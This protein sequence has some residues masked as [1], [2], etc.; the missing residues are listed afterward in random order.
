MTFPG[1][2]QNAAIS[3]STEIGL[4][5][6]LGLKAEISS[7]VALTA[8][9]NFSGDVAGAAGWPRRGLLSSTLSHARLVP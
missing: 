3:G 7:S 5:G 4:Y 9:F 6:G 8:Q 1:Q 2:T